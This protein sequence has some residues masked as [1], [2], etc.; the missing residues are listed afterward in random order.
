M[1]IF[2]VPFAS[3]KEMDALSTYESSLACVRSCEISKP[4][5]EDGDVSM[6]LA[7]QIFRNTKRVPIAGNT[8]LHEIMRVRYLW[9]SHPTI[10]VDG[11]LYKIKII[12]ETPDCV[13]LFQNMVRALERHNG[14]Q[15]YEVITRRKVKIFLNPRP[16]SHGTVPKLASPPPTWNVT[17]ATSSRFSILSCDDED[18]E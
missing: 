11:C 3:F 7:E 16:R 18:D 17:N 9:P 14:K 4:V 12:K 13:E 8:I 2:S 6:Q 5:S 10:V 15:W 1:R